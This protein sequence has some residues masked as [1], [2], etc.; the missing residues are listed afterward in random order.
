VLLTR[1]NERN[2]CGKDEVFQAPLR[3]K[4]DARFSQEISRIYLTGGRWDQ[5][6][7]NIEL[8][9]TLNACWERCG[10]EDVEI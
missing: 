4:L 10:E 7:K 2:F 9:E 8:I 5:Q 6:A 1:L 3:R